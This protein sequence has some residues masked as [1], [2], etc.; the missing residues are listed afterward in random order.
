MCLV[1]TCSTFPVKLI[2][3]RFNQFFIQIVHWELKT[4]CGNKNKNKSST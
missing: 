1:E 3:V 4:P 2:R